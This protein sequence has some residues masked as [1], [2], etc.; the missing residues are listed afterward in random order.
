MLLRHRPPRIDSRPPTTNKGFEHLDQRWIA[1][2]QW[3]KA[4]RVEFV[5]VGPAA[6][7]VRG[8]ME[9]TGPVAIVPAP[10][11]RNFE[12]LSRALVATGAV[13]RVDIGDDGDTELMQVKLT[14]EKLGRGQLWTVRCGEYDLDI[15]GRR[16]STPSYQEVLYE[17]GRVQLAPDLSVEVAS[18]EHIEHYSHVRR[19]GLSPEIKITRTA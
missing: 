15:E 2:L 10:Y 5:L 11:G 8:G 18:P 19:T 13:V 17:A 3:L 16:A 14:P 7:A 9:A 6:E 1:V 12:R 4:N